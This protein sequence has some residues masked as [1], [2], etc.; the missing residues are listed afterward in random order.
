[1]AGKENGRKHIGLIDVLSGRGPGIQDAD[2]ETPARER[3]LKRER[4]FAS[5]LFADIGGSTDIVQNMDPE[6]ADETLSP[7]LWLMRRSVERHGGTL[8]KMQGDGIVALF[9]APRATEHH[10]IAACHA[11]IDIQRELRRSSRAG[12]GVRIGIHSAEVLVEYSA[13]PDD[14]HCDAVGPAMHL[15]ARM[16]SAAD[17]GEICVTEACYALSRS[18]VDA[19]GPT[20]FI[21][22]GF[23]EAVNLYKLRSHDVTRSRW[24][25]RSELGLS[26][27]HSREDEVAR[28]ADR[29][30][31]LERDKGWAVVIDGPAGVGKS[32]LIHEACLK[33]A[34]ASRY[35]FTVAGSADGENCSYLPITRALRQTLA[36]AEQDPMERQLQRLDSWLEAIGG[37]AERHRPAFLNLLDLPVASDGWNDLDPSERRAAIHDATVDTLIRLS[38]KRPLVALLEDVH[39]YDSETR[40]VVEGLCQVVGEHPIGLLVTERTGGFIDLEELARTGRVDRLVLEALSDETAVELCLDLLG[41]TDEMRALAERL[42][43]KSAGNPLFVE[44]FVH[45]LIATG[46]LVPEDDGYRLDRPAEELAIP[47]SVQDVVAARIDA[48][49]ARAK[50]VLQ[51]ASACGDVVPSELLP[52]VSDLGEFDVAGALSELVDA[53]LL[54]E[55]RLLPTPRY[56]FAHALV[57]E[58]CYAGIPR[59][60]RPDMHR[61]IA[62][63][64]VDRFGTRIE[65]YAESLARH[66]R[67]GEMWPE[68]ARYAR[69]AGRRALERSAYADAIA[70]LS[71]AAA[72]CDLLERSQD[73]LQAAV[74]IQLELRAPLGA[75]AQLDAMA[76]GLARA[77]ELCDELGDERRLAAVKVSQAFANNCL[78]RLD[79][80]KS[81]AWEGIDLAKRLE[82]RAL[83]VGG[84]YHLAQ[85]HQWSGDFES[86]IGLLEPWCADFASGPIRM[87]RLGTA[88][89]VSVLWHG[90]VGA[91]KAYLGEFPGAMTFLRRAVLIATETERPYD[92]IMA[93]WYRGFAELHAGQ[94]VTGALERLARARGLCDEAGILFLK[95]VVATSLGYGMMMV[96]KW[97]PAIRLLEAAAAGSERTGLRYGVVWAACNLGA[98]I[99]GSGDRQRGR[100]VLERAL[101]EARQHAFRAVEVTAVRYLALTM[102]W[103]PETADTAEE[104]LVTALSEAEE[105]GLLPE[106]A[107]LYRALADA[108]DRRGDSDGA[109][110]FR[111]EALRRY[112]ELDMTLWIERTGG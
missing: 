12:I 51:A 5:I 23:S 28:I 16:E 53:K 110:E 59:R 15:A 32:R 24:Q 90:L 89:T 49:S 57:Q 79:I 48:Q 88:G 61:K 19:A 86:V 26:P 63:A 80:A 29:L 103:D 7:V 18:F 4:K 85:A 39:W 30:R 6:E 60:T 31:S 67:L 36:I 2:S 64:I 38:R 22:K 58:V 107:H 93:N 106:I 50:T 62:Q 92:L 55:T 35:V 78:G 84:I 52:P 104:M 13:N 14:P 83:M 44:E 101:A 41:S 97:E 43:E 25:A 99:S 65:E 82:E 11:A 71:E 98:A 17:P 21:P 10:A 68:T 27:F 33:T 87:Q 8:S 105:M 112:R 46:H 109:A 66:C 70:F 47:T 94:D 73:N 42:A 54:V 91:A 74:D 111:S 20:S 81:A 34:D 76:A 102:A 40:A 77:E 75:A 56:G 37:G 9:G 100:D 72:A 3:T 95:P 96:G 1:M 69:V 108:K 45:H